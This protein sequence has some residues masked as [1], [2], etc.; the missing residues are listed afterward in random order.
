VICL[1]RSPLLTLFPL[2]CTVIPNDSEGSQLPYN[3]YINK[4]LS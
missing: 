3:V 4:I 2:N 1:G